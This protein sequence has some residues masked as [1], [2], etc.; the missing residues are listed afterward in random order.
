MEKYIVTDTGIAIRTHIDRRLVA[1][2]A[3]WCIVMQVAQALAYCHAQMPNV[4]HRDI[5]PENG[6]S[7]KSKLRVPITVNVQ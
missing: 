2:K 3:I 5:K 6:R 7:F 1:E 4:V